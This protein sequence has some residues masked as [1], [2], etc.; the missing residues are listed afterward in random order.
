MVRVISR[1]FFKIFKVGNLN[2]QACNKPIIIVILLM[3]VMTMTTIMIMII[4]MI[5]LLMWRDCL[6]EG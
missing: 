1:A 4:T 6:A 3:M 5:T 2:K